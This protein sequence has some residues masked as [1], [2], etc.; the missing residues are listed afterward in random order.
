MNATK[1]APAAPTLKELQLLADLCSEEE[2]TALVSR[3]GFLLASG[4][5]LEAMERFMSHTLRR[6]IS[7]SKPS[8]ANPG[9]E[10]L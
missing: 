8:V 10:K 6:K 1:T 7:L 3:R 2:W 5:S 4:D 9:D